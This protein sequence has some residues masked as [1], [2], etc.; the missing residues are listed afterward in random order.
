MFASVSRLVVAAAGAASGK[1]ISYQ[2]DTKGVGAQTAY[3][4]EVEVRAA[5]QAFQQ[6]NKQA[7]VNSQTVTKQASKQDTSKAASKEGKRKG[8]KSTSN[9][10]AH[11]E[12]VWLGEPRS[13]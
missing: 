5:K 7:R 6:V 1:F 4:V 9:K 13:T 10:A 8:G 2:D 11:L 12:S 3:G